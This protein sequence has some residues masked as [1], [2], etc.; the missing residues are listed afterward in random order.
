[1][2]PLAS[3]KGQPL[4]HRM[5]HDQDIGK[6]DRAVETEPPDRLHG[7]FGGRFAIVN[8]FEEPALFGPKFPVFRQIASRLAHQ[9]DGGNVLT[10]TFER[11]E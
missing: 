1:M 9:P 11:I 2:R 6:Q 5:R 7:D 3:G 8:Q 10:D 4:P